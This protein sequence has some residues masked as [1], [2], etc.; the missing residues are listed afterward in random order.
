MYMNSEKV[1]RYSKVTCYSSAY[2]VIPDGRTNK[3]TDGWTDGRMVGRIFGWMDRRMDRQTD[4]L[5]L[6]FLQNQ[7]TVLFTSLKGDHCIELNSSCYFLAEFSM[8]TQAFEC[9]G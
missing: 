2:P 1:S 7:E 8:E 5:Y 3:W 6:V 4:K 9:S